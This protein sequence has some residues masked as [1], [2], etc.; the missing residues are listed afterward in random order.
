[1]KNISKN[2]QNENANEFSNFINKTDINSSDVNFGNQLLGFLTGSKE[3]LRNLANDIGADLGINSGLIKQLLPMIAPM[4]VGYFN[5][6][7]NQNPLS[8]VTKF[9]DKDGDDSIIDDVMGLASNF[10]YLFK[11]NL[12]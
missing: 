4:I 5:N 11:R 9:L 7:S 6:G 2:L 1:M 12:L 3:N 8:I 10:L